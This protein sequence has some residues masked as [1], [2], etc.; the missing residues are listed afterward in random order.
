MYMLLLK[1]YIPLLL[2]DSAQNY[3]HLYDTVC[4][5]RCNHNLIFVTS[6]LV[7]SKFLWYC[8]AIYDILYHINFGIIRPGDGLL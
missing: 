8:T 4:I 1:I 2:P 3:V 5:Q 6:V 7:G